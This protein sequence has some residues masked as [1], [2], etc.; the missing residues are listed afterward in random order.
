MKKMMSVLIV[1]IMAFGCPRNPL[2]FER[3]SKKGTGADGQPG[4]VTAQV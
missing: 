1:P 4:V 3:A 2:C